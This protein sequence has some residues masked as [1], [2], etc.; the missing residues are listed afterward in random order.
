MTNETQEQT[1]PIFTIYVGRDPRKGVEG[2]YTYQG[3]PGIS[4]FH[5]N[6]SLG[7]SEEDF[8]RFL[9]QDSK[10]AGYELGEEIHRLGVDLVRIINGKLW[11]GQLESKDW[12]EPGDFNLNPYLVDKGKKRNFYDNG[13][14]NLE[15]V[16]ALEDHE[17]WRVMDGIKSSLYSE[18]KKPCQIEEGYESR[19]QVYAIP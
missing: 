12:F 10:D 5:G 7:S 16:E 1:K 19:E 8:R 11:L 3:E 18:G 13:P 4:E 9:G 14:S 6:K 17:V 2:R 15:E